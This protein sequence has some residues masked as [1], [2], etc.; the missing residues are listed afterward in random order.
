MKKEI[1]EYFKKNPGHK[2]KPREL[3]K[4]LSM[5]NEENYASLKQMLHDLSNE[6][7]L[8]KQGKRYFLSYQPDNNLIGTFQL[9]REGTYGFVIIKDYDVPDIFVP[10]KFFNTAIHGDLVKV[11]LQSRQRGKNIEGKIIE[12]LERKHAE[13]IGD[14]VK[15][16]S[17][18]FVFPDNNEIQT[19]IYIPHEHL[20]DAGVGDKVVVSNILWESNG[21]NPEGIIVEVLGKS[22]SYEVERKLVMKE[23]HLPLSFSRDAM[24]EAD[25][26]T[27]DIT[28]DEINKRIDLR[29]KIVF[30]IDP[31]DAR[32]FDDAV[33]IEKRSDGNF[34]IG[35]HIAD[36]SHFLKK[37]TAVYK[38][39]AKRA[40]SVYLVGNVVPMLPEKLSNNICSLVPFKDRLTYS[41]ILTVTPEAAIVDYRIGKSVINSKRRFTYEEVQDILNNKNGEFFWELNELNKI[42]RILRSRRIQKGSINFIRPEVKFELSD[43]G[44]PFN[45][46]IKRIQESNEL[47]EELML[48][49]NQ[50]VASHVKKISGKNLLSFIYRVHD[51]PEEEKMSEFARFV[52]SL[53]YKFNT[54]IKNKSK[55]LQKLLDQVKGTVEEAVINEIAIRSMAKAVYSTE[56]IGHYGLGFKNYTHFT[57]PIRRFPDLIVHKLLYKYLENN[58]A[59]SYSAK[60]LENICS[61][62]SSMERN[63]VSAERTSIKLK[64]IEYLKNKIGYEY[65]GII[66]GVTNFGIFVELNEN[67]AEGLIRL[68]DIED[69]YYILDE[70]HYSIIGRSSKQIYRL[71]DR[72][73]VK[74]VR[75]DEEKQEIDFILIN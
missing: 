31:E 50:T 51:V 71:G 52:T 3:A 68:R 42:A 70:K 45:I 20:H 26:M 1:K 23:Y 54:R 12:V 21:V 34:E 62:S 72:I 5:L 47:I 53:G 2:I 66:S 61:H 7:Y 37:G 46:V 16:K 64:Q 38:E 10:E 8:D 17:A 36:V 73:R 14:L 69:D 29:H 33:S 43:D 24:A 49:A 58:S 32:D 57:S 18:Y 11:E 41:V 22:G 56:N 13:I 67:L 59:E 60:E 40:T 28:N 75:V 44:K 63:A 74:V 25:C 6:G 9:S 35:I 65:D 39:A 48:L 55:E 30:T 27:E 15:R 4:K 19:D